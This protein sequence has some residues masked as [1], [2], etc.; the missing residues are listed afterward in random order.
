[1]CK[2]K[3]EPVDSMLE[4]GPKIHTRACGSAPN[5]T[6]VDQRIAVDLPPKREPELEG[7]PER[8]IQTF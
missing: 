8:E 5:A 3:G 6:I 2:R 4:M 7:E 1:M